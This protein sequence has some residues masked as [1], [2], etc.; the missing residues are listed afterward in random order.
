MN[1][2][3]K[4]ESPGKITLIFMYSFILTIIFYISLFLVFNINSLKTL[5]IFSS[6]F[7][8]IMI[9]LAIIISKYIEKIHD[10][11]ENK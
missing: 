2:N 9:V 8:L 5:L 4:K 7:F 6:I 3:N 11:I 10:K 1:T